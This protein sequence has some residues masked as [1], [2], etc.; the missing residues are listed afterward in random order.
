MEKS[1]AKVYSYLKFHSEKNRKTVIVHSPQARDYA[2]QLEEATWV[3]NYSTCYPLEAEGLPH[4]NPVGIRSSYFETKWTSDF[5]IQYADG[6][7]GIR[8]LAT[9]GQL[10]KLANIERLE[11][12]RRYW[13]AM[14]IDDWAIVLVPEKVW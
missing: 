14:G 6:R 12:S 10:R 4:V 7:R 8:E 11:L 13:A 2:R 9:R 1:N 3:K 5:F